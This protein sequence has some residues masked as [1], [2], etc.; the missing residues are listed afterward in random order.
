MNHSIPDAL[1]VA[2]T[3]EAGT[4]F[5]TGDFKADMTP[6]DGRLTNMAAFYRLGDRGVDLLLSDWTNADVPGFVATQRDIG[7]VLDR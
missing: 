2:V 3:T 7:P 4:L 6:L 5:H 1:A